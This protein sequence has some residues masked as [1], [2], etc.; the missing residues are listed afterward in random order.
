MP[1]FISAD[2]LY[3]LAAGIEQWHPHSLLCMLARAGGGGG[4]GVFYQENEYTTI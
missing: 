1:S 2:L 4:G 3:L